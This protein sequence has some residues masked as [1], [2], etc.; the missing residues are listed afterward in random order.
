MQQK[1]RRKQSNEQTNK[2][3]NKQANKQTTDAT[4]KQSC[5]QQ[6]TKGNPAAPPATTRPR[7]SREPYLH[8]NIPPLQHPPPPMCL[9]AGYSR[10]CPTMPQ[11]FGHATRYTC[12]GL[13]RRV[14]LALTQASPESS[15]DPVANRLTQHSRATVPCAAQRSQ[16]GLVA[17]LLPKHYGSEP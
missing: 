12:S 6:T 8:G 10:L 1:A 2:Q 14:R 17:S 3:T 4:I 16:K 7:R 11:A 9:L 15:L 13:L 5:E